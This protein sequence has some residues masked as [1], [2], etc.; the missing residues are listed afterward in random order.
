M[1]FFAVLKGCFATYVVGVAFSWANYLHS[2]WQ[3]KLHVFD[4][5]S[6]LFVSVVYGA[7]FAAPIAIFVVL[8]W[9]ILA[10]RK[11]TVKFYL[12]PTISAVLVGLMMWAL[13]G[14]T[15][16]AL[17]LGAFWGVFFGT[18]FWVFT[19]GRSESADLRLGL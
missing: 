19:F 6:S 14:G 17:L 10:W 9:V 18:V 5:W 2:Y 7:L 11:V 16:Y 13:N 12:A 8:L 4:Q 15:I 1:Q 3:G